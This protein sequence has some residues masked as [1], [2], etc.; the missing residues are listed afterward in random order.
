MALW[1]IHEDPRR[2]VES[3]ASSP[4]LE[5]QRLKDAEQRRRKAAAV[6]AKPDKRL[7]QRNPNRGV[8][9]AGSG[10]SA[11][12]PNARKMAIVARRQLRRRE[13]N[14]RATESSQSENDEAE[15]G[16]SDGAA[17]HQEEMFLLW[18][19]ATIS[20]VGG[21]PP[22]NGS[23][24][25]ALA[26]GAVLCD[27]ICALTGAPHPPSMRRA[28]LSRVHAIENANLALT[29]L[30]NSG[31]DVG[32]DVCAED[33]VDKASVPV[34]GFVWM[35]FQRFVG[36]M[37]ESLL[38]K[39]E[40]VA[41]LR[42]QQTAAERR[43]DA[44]HAEAAA[45]RRQLQQLRATQPADECVN[46]LRLELEQQT[47]ALQ[48][49]KSE[50]A[51]VSNECEAMDAQLTAQLGL[52]DRLRSE[53][54][55]NTTLKKALED[56]QAEVTEL[57]EELDTCRAGCQVAVDAYSSAAKESASAAENSENDAAEAR[58]REAEALVKLQ[59][60]S[61]V[62]LE[63][64][65]EVRALRQQ[66]EEHLQREPPQMQT[67]TTQTQA[68]DETQRQTK[69]QAQQTQT[70]ST[71]IARQ[72]SQTWLI[73]S[74]TRGTEDCLREEVLAERKLRKGAEASATAW[75]AE[76]DA[77]LEHL[78]A[79]YGTGRGDA[80]LGVQC[81]GWL[82]RKEA[83]NDPQLNS[84]DDSIRSASISGGM[85]WKRRWAVLS[86][87]QLSFFRGTSDAGAI[88]TVSL[89]GAAIRTA[90]PVPPPG[91]GEEHGYVTIERCDNRHYDPLRHALA[92][93]LD[94]S[95]GCGARLSLRAPSQA[96]MQGWLSALRRAVS[97]CNR[98]A[99][100]EERSG[101]MLE[102]RLA[103]AT[104]QF[105]QS[106]QPLLEEQQPPLGL[107]SGRLLLAAYP[108]KNM[109]AASRCFGPDESSS[110]EAASPS[111][112]PLQLSGVSCHDS[113]SL[114]LLLSACQNRATSL[115][116]LELDR[117][118]LGD[119]GMLGL[120]SLLPQL[121][122]LKSLSLA[123]NRLSPAG[124]RSLLTFLAQ[125][126]WQDDYPVERD[127]IE[128]AGA[129]GASVATELE[130]LRLDGND[131]GSALVEDED[132]AG[133]LA[134]LDGLKHLSVAGCKLGKVSDAGRAAVRF[135]PKMLASLNLAENGFV[136][137]DLG[138][139]GGCPPPKA[140]KETLSGS[141]ISRSAVGKPPPPPHPKENNADKQTKSK[142]PPP[143]QPPPV[144]GTS[145]KRAATATAGLAQRRPGPLIVALQ[146]LRELGTLDM[147]GN[148]IGC[149]G[150]G[151]IAAC[152]LRRRSRLAELSLCSCGIDTPGVRVLAAVMEE[153][154]E[155][156]AT[157]VGEEGGVNG[158]DGIQRGCS[159][160]TTI[161]LAA[162][163]T[164]G[165]LRAG[166]SS[167]IEVLTVLDPVMST[168]C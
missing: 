63:R 145:S 6:G 76:A 92:F 21:T 55:Q 118:H 91:R 44:A 43:A 27:L 78:A 89:H 127:K 140:K 115:H 17:W 5:L 88:S 52:A 50:L 150:A 108:M 60:T 133:S 82:E 79:A 143:S 83:S 38:R 105:H 157:I 152:L 136:S 62:A 37:S 144:D 98:V 70:I 102:M 116:S 42:E 162:N 26:N 71:Q 18:V 134:Q 137:A 101:L 165:A 99:E 64:Q 148:P 41:S 1:T 112:L 36:R 59:Q 126:K 149:H 87:G 110:L 84:S 96:D 19:R 45:L 29:T 124:L 81:V 20:S 7:Q 100:A 65:Q 86:G 30:K 67:Q 53:K 97:F 160:V 163:R 61:V 12:S 109:S 56:A 35:L 10:S 85:R 4:A 22:S 153:A 107:L 146:R 69:T 57:L 139:G 9:G 33:F 49:V 111:S 73:D 46:N 122:S 2:E 161:R 13:R 95:D 123:D 68:G 158:E 15:R 121:H 119:H 156:R 54:E 167:S 23:I 154:A 164:R 104:S 47:R 151:S 106:S 28:A 32:S 51:D 75:R 80:V 131:L 135:L 147:S 93:R 24:V 66:L 141:G 155:H 34:I 103:A 3:P 130:T 114:R 90:G 129:G 113:A 31:V 14:A 168:S 72:T 58:E 25:E 128:T 94:L 159:S 142:P 117:C 138:C 40:Q 74:K 11:V 166:V 120:A 39:T 77:G 125:R 132:L 8:A 48:T 16:A